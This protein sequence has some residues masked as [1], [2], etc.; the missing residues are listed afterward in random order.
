M[1][2]LSASSI[3]DWKQ[4]Q[5]L[6]ALR[7]FYEFD[8]P[9]SIWTAVG[10]AA[11]ATIENFGKDERPLES[12]FNEQF[13]LHTKDVPTNGISLSRIKQGLLLSLSQID[14]GRFKAEREPEHEVYFSRDFGDVK[15]RGYVDCITKDGTIYEWK[16]SAKKII[17]VD[18]H[19]QQGAIYREM[20][21]ASNVYLVYFLWRSGQAKAFKLNGAKS[22]IPEIEAIAHEVNDAVKKG[23]FLKTGD[24]KKCFLKKECESRAW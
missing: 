23:V 15:F 18:E 22:F 20:L 7:R 11:H 17:P 8:E 12:V 21:S 5:R 2:E 24:C 16:T 13:K 14:W 6:W 9:P 19:V 1:I 10:K 3:G 4:C